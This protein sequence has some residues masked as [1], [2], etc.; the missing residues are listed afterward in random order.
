[1][2]RRKALQ[3]F[4]SLTIVVVIVCA[5]LPAKQRVRE[6]PW[7]ELIFNQKSIAAGTKHFSQGFDGMLPRGTLTDPNDRDLHGWMSD[8]L[9]HI[10]Q[11]PVYRMIR[12]DLPWQ[13]PENQPAFRKLIWMY[14]GYYELTKTDDHG[15]ALSHFA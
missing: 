11:E 4:I 12:F 7:G 10:D 2:K 1:M 6:T 14:Q 3:A 13:A 15:F 5:L 8:I 9:P